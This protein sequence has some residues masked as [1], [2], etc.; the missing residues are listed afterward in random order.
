MKL[1]LNENIRIYRKKMSLTQGQLA[2]AMGVSV[3]T[4][5]KWENGSISPDIGMVAELADFFQI[6]VDVLLGYQ[7]KKHSA[8]QCVE[9]IHQLSRERQNEELLL[10]INKALQKYPNNFKVLYECGK[11]LFVYAVDEF[12][13]EQGMAE[14][15]GIEELKRAI[16]V[17]KKALE[18]FEENTDKHIS[19]EE[20][21]QN[22]GNI[23]A[24]MG[25][26]EK[27]VAYLEEHN[28]CNINDRMLGTLLCNMQEF[29]R[30]EVYLSRT[31][32]R[33]LLDLWSNYMGLW[34][35]LVNKGKYKDA[36]ESALWLRNMYKV[37]V[38]DEGSYFMRA[39]AMLDAMVA[40]SYA[41]KEFGEKKD[42][43]KEI[44]DYLQLALEEAKRFDANP[45][46]SGRIRF[47]TFEEEYMHDSFGDTTVIAVKYVIQCFIQESQVKDRLTSILDDLLR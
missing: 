14:N 19:R 34:V 20:I 1:L 24:F 28:V 15:R 29:D 3:A 39:T 36:L 18:L 21:H 26:F 35:V 31:H 13:N 43:T 45:D 22:I 30:A 12:R 25:E 10:E 5:S 8:K 27:A 4:V 42:S 7:W 32:R 47:I 23:Y 33:V 40:S 16:E 46:Y 17:S 11:A 37:I 41:Y 38:P 44:T 6:S 2:E 9:T